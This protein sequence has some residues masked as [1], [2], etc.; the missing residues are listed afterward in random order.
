M[1]DDQ[2]EL[3]QA[4][5]PATPAAI[6]LREILGASWADV[7]KWLASTFLNNDVEKARRDAAFKRDELYEGR[8][9]AYLE[10][11]IQA[12]FESEFNQDLRKAMLEWARWNNVIFRI[13]REKATVYSQPATRHITGN[14]ELY[15]K[16]VKALRMDAVMKELNRKLVLHED[17]WIQYRVRATPRGRR[18]ALDVIS[19]AKFWAIHHPKDKTMLIGIILDQ[20]PSDPS[21]LANAPYTA[22]YRVLTD[23]ET[24]QLDAACR[25]MEDTVQPWP[26]G[27]MPGVLASVRPPTTK[28]CLLSRTPCSDI[29]SAHLAVWFLNCL[30]LK[31]SKSAN[32]QN[33]LSGDTADVALGQDA[34]TETEVALPEGV[35]VQS[36]DRGM[37]LA[38]FRDT[39]S[40]VIDDAGANHGLPPS[41]RKLADASSGA[42]VYL[43]RLPLHELRLE[44]IDVCRDA[45]REMA[46]IEAAV[47]ALENAG[48]GVELA[49]YLF[50]S[51]G[52]SIDY[53]EIQQPET[54][55]ERNTNFETERRLGLTDTVEETMERNPDLETPEAADARIELHT[56]RETKRVASMKTLMS[57]NGSPS[58]PQ[59]EATPT[60]NGAQGKDAGDDD[61]RRPPPP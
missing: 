21:L 24:F 12:A 39:S 31:E 52:F 32:R 18:P 54:R 14:D 61:P 3:E 11:M 56:A 7:G 10:E 36:V 1:A 51:D 53:A 17:V 57:L 60:Q 16:F 45:E 38:Q 9:D 2:L 49:D 58:S 35:N 42:E 47:N 8:G 48:G 30:L 44:Q 6:G 22:C 40:A 20:S 34:D 15:Q 43:R 23:A 26:L 25:V 55:A 19:P 27:R 50:Q 46:E 41:V 37:D 33:Y 59:L 13:V 4:G 29:V 28:D 5:A